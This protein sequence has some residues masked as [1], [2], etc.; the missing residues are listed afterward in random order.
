VLKEALLEAKTK[1]WE[2]ALPRLYDL[3]R[4]AE[5]QSLVYSRNLLQLPDLDVAKHQ[6]MIANRHAELIA[7]AI[8]TF[9]AQLFEEQA[10][11]ESM[12]IIEY[13]R[14]HS[15]CTIINGSM[16]N[17]GGVV[18]APGLKIATITYEP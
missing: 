2:A 8:N 9:H 16:S 5:R 17:S 18:V 7:D 12:A 14:A 3:L 11:A 15:V 4:K 13:L 1:A 6:E 10:D